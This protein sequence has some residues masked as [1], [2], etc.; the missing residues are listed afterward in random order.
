MPIGCTPGEKRRTEK[1]PEQSAL[2][3]SWYE[4]T[5]AVERVPDLLAFETD[6]KRTDRRVWLMIERGEGA[7][8]ESPKHQLGQSTGRQ[9][10]DDYVESGGLDDT[11]AR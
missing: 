7:F 9:G 2:F 1:H 11:C 5:K 6:E 3:A 4:R 8:A 10:K